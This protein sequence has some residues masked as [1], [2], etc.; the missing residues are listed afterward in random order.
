V[1]AALDTNILVYAEGVNDAEKKRKAWELLEKLPDDAVIPVQVLGE[2]FQ[3]L[4]RKAG[5]TPHDARLAVSRWSYAFPLVETSTSILLA[6]TDLATRQFGLWDAVIL[7]AAAEAGCGLLLSE[8]MQEGFVWRDVMVVN[9]FS[10]T[11]HL[12]LKALLSR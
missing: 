8:D 12:M 5:R 9:P 2:L 7:S 4:V 3:V 11:P 10:K 6:A 1:K